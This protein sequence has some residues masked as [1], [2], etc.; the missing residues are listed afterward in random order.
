MKM[1][2]AV[3][4]AFKPAEVREALTAIGQKEITVPEV[5]GTGQQKGHTELQRGAEYVLDF[6]PKV[7]LEMGVAA[8]M[9]DNVIET[10]RE[11][12]NTG[13]GKIFAYSKH[14]VR[15]RTGEAGDEAL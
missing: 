2:T 10:I 6:P 9:V 15:I 3:I 4:A 13:G 5:K 1:I 8:K 7:K 14:V 11:A 12:A